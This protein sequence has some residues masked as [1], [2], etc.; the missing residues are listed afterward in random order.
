MA[1]LGDHHGDR[2][3]AL[4]VDGVEGDLLS[5]VAGHRLRRAETPL[6][7][8]P[9]GAVGLAILLPGVQHGERRTSTGGR[10]LRGDHTTATFTQWIGG[11]E[12]NRHSHSSP[13]SRPDP[14]LAGRGAEVERGRLQLVDVHRVAQHREE[15]LL[16]R[17][18]LARAASTSRRRS[19]CARPR[20]RRPDRCASSGSSG[21]T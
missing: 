17:Q 5:R 16:L 19:R 11:S 15:A 12:S 10:S 1:G 14:E 4:L 20:A 7:G 13:P 18:A 2:H 9:R 8:S 6:A 21:T 3:P